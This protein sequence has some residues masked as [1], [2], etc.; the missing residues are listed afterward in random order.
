MAKMF[1][2]IW[3]LV[4]ILWL[5]SYTGL[6]LKLSVLISNF[7][8]YVIAFIPSELLF[9]FVLIWFW[10]AFKVYQSVVH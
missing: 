3:L 8:K 7:N 1:W 9:L 5:S 10:L 4:V 6:L 2:S